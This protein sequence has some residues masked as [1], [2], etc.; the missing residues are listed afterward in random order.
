MLQSDDP[1]ENSSFLTREFLKIVEKYAP[2]RKKFFRD[3][4]APFKNKELRKA[5]SARFKL[6]ISFAKAHRKRTR[7]FIKSNGGNAYLWGEKSI[8]KY[9]NG[10]TKYGILT[11]KNVWRLIKPFLTNKGHFNHQDIMI[12]DGEKIITNETGLVEVFNNHDISI[13]EVF[14]DH[15]ISIVEKSSGTCGTW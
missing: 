1:D 3:N 10:I 4:H 14:N 2:L 5:I 7:L 15:D 11:N 13:V 8:K 9:F 6:R 12:F